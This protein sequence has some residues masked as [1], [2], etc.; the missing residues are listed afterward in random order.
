MQRFLAPL[1]VKPLSGM[2]DGFTDAIGLRQAASTDGGSVVT[3]QDNDS[4]VGSRAL[5]TVSQPARRLPDD[6]VEAPPQ[7]V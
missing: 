6:L 3:E 4:T 2:V 5:E 1:P 7:S